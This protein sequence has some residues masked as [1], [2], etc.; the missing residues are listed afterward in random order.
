[1]NA[2][3]RSKKSLEPSGRLDDTPPARS[4]NERDLLRIA[5]ISTALA[6][7]TVLGSM[8]S[9]QQ[10][11]SGFLF[12]FSGG[13]VIAFMVGAAVALLYWKLVS[14]SEARGA[15]R[16]LRISSSLLLLGAVGV[17]LY[18][19]RFLASEKLAEV[20]Q[21][22]VA[23]ALALSLLGFIL[24]Q[25]KRFLDRDAIRAADVPEKSSA[26]K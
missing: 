6:F 23:A 15:S 1:M 20:R 3:A 25:I 8:A 17:F 9:L 4:K 12:H 14:L 18:P 2:G 26:N 21:G 7:G 11:G 10:D 5:S 19:L 22:L 13:T 16:L 24:W